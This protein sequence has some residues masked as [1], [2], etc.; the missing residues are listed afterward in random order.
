MATDPSV[1]LALTSALD[2]DAGNNALRVHLAALSLESSF[3]KEAP[4]HCKVVLAAQP[5]NVEAL[6]QASA[7]AAAI[8]DAA[9]C[10]SFRRLYEALTW[11]QTRGLLDEREVPPLPDL[12]ERQPAMSKREPPGS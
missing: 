11:Q 7:E 3:A 9:R 10:E 2:S 12:S 1:I 4:D 8:G 5:D 6:K